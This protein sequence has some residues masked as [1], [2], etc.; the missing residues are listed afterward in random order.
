MCR[1]GIQEIIASG[2]NTCNARL[3]IEAQPRIHHQR[4]AI[5]PCAQRLQ[6]RQRRQQHLLLVRVSVERRGR[7]GG[8]GWGG[9]GWAG[10]GWGGRQQH[11]HLVLEYEEG[12]GGARRGKVGW[13]RAGWVGWEAA[14]PPPRAS[15][16]GGAGR[17]GAGRGGAGRGGAGRGGAGQVGQVGQVGRGGAGWGRWV[18]G[19]G[20]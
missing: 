12:L 10:A 16:S 2:R 13:G 6:P 1:E 5:R 18:G 3:H 11:L 4:R 14:A 8:V 7:W 17:G 15:S 19:V 9:V 20:V